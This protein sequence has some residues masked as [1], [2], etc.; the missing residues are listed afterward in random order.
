MGGFK[1]FRN[2]NYASYYDSQFT[3]KTVKHPDYV[4]VRVTFSENKGRKYLCLLPENI[5]MKVCIQ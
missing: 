2:P 5:P 3:V 1:F 4:I